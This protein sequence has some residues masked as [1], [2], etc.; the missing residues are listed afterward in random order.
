MQFAP[1]RR[2]NDHVNVDAGCFITCAGL[3]NDETFRR[4]MTTRGQVLHHLH[5]PD[6]HR[7]DAKDVKELEHLFARYVGKAPIL[8]TTEKDAVKLHPLLPLHIPLHV[9]P[10]QVVMGDAMDNLIDAIEDYARN[11]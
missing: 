2:W 1:I 6:H 9:L 3:A 5:R 10:M 8:V 7:Y 11:Y 4:E